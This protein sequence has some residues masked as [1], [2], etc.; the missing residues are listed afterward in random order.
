MSSEH[1]VDWE[2]KHIFDNTAGVAVNLL[3]SQ[4]HGNLTSPVTKWFGLRFRDEKLNTDVAAK[5]WL[6]DSEDR[7]WQAIQ[8]SNFDTMAPEMYLDI[9]SFGTSV[10]MMED[11]NDLVWEGVTFNAI[12]MMDTQFESGPNGLPYRVYRM[13]RYTQLELEDTFDLPAVLK[14]KDREDSSVDTKIEVIFAVYKE[15]KNTRDAPILAPT[16]RPVQWRYVHKASGKILKKKG[17]QTARGGYYD[18]PAMTV[19]WQKTAGSRW[20]YSPAMQMISD[21]KQ[22]NELVAQTTEAVAKAIDPPLKST[23]LG[24]VGDLENVPGGLTLVTSMDDIEPL[25]PATSFNPAYE[26]RDRAQLAIRAGFYVDKLELKDS[27]QM[28]KYEVQVRY[29]RMLRL[30]APTLG[31]LKA[32]FLMPVIEGLFGKL[33][34]AGQLEEMPEVLDR[35]EMDI[36]FTGPLPRAMKGEVADGMELWLVGLTGQYEF[37]PEVLDIVDWDQYNRTMAEQRGVPAKVTKTAD[38]VKVVR[39]ERAERE[40]EQREIEKVRAAG[41]AA[42]QAGKGAEAVQ[43]AGGTPE[44][45]Q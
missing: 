45:V 16:L 5:E 17:A 15:P 1:E 14:V 40:N 37:N 28:T 10:V 9:G 26:E 21:I 24:V 22:L 36:E 44:A 31:R 18:F 23:E 19:R 8:E 39:D 32:D 27:P 42:E 20:G 11:V 41:E 4:M 12:A 34:R 33:Q 6:E 3:A 35:V 30:L 43:A 2:R 29:E 38:E 13:L 7:L 25:Y